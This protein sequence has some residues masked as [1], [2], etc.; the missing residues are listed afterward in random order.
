MHKEIKGTLWARKCSAT[1]EGMNEGYCVFDGE[2][3][4]K[5]EKDLIKY[6][7]NREQSP[8]DESSGLSDEFLLN[9]A[10]ELDEYYW[11]KWEDITDYQYF[12]QDGKLIEIK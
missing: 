8:S 12:E 9:E 3:Y 7:R 5:Y 4:F 10:Y 2:E 6:L 1:G 11:T